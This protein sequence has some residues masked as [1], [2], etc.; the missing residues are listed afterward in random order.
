MR[1]NTESLAGFAVMQVL[2]TSFLKKFVQ[3]VQA[4]ESLQHEHVVICSTCLLDMATV[5]VFE[6]ALNGKQVLGPNTMT[7]PAVDL[8]SCSPAWSAFG[9]NASPMNP[10]SALCN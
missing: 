3:R 10:S 7:L 1:V 9:S 8:E 5:C 4:S 2:P 6:K